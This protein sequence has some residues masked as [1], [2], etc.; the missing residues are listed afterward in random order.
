MAGILD[1]LTD[2]NHQREYLHQQQALESVNRQLAIAAHMHTLHEELATKADTADF[3][4]KHAQLDPTHP[5]YESDVAHLLA[6]HPR[7]QGQAVTDALGSARATR[8]T[9]LNAVAP[10]GADEFTMGSPEHQAYINRF[11]QTQDPVAARAHALNT[12]KGEEMVK[13]AI[14]KKLIDPAKDFPEWDGTEQNRPKVYNP[15]GTVNYHELGFIAATR[16]GNEESLAGQKEQKKADEQTYRDSLGILNKWNSY[17]DKY[18]EEQK[19][20]AEGVI[21]KQAKDIVFNK[22]KYGNINGPTG[23]NVTTT[24]PAAKPTGGSPAPVND[25]SAFVP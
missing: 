8:T 9:Y 20:S 25:A 17:T 18:Q 6:S 7:T 16:A 4:T 14:S 1:L 13:T 19:D 3:L 24:A 5:T 12:A 23:T 21:A 10:G 15:D 22:A 11:Q 2:P